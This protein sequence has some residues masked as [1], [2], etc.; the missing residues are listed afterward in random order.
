VGKAGRLTQIFV[1]ECS[2]QAQFQT[3]E[4]FEQAVKVFML[5]FDS[6]NKNQ[7]LHKELYKSELFIQHDAMKNSPFQASLNQLKERS[8]KTAL[9]LYGFRGL[10]N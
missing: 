1:N 10:F 3:V 6:I 2:L 4:H 8:L 5:V 7:H 9:A